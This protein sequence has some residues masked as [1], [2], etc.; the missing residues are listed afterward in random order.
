MKS[1]SKLKLGE[2]NVIFTDIQ[3][4]NQM[5]QE[6]Q[7]K[8]PFSELSD[9]CLYKKTQ[10]FL[11]KKFKKLGFVPSFFV[12]DDTFFCLRVICYN[13]RGHIHESVSL[14]PICS[15][16]GMFKRFEINL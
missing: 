2:N 5:L 9:Y 16:H 3:V 15:A 4:I 1:F 8:V 12:K 6:G 11:K 14:L 13:F 7:K 10:N